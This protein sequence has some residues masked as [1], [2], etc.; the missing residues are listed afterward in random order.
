MNRPVWPGSLAIEPIARRHQR[1]SFDCGQARV[2]DWIRSKALQNHEKR[3]SATR[4]LADGI[5][6]A[7]YYTL[8]N[9]EIS[10][11]DLPPAMVKK[12]PQRHLPVAIIAWLGLDVRYQKQGLGE[13]LLGS[14]LCDVI[15]SGDFVPHVA[16]VIDSISPG[17]KSFFQRYQFEELP[18]QPHR[19]VVPWS[20]IVKMME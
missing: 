17:S 11:A 9:A 8:A 12:L 6:V 7:G 3:M 2:N 14:A 1:S 16:V 18:G 20:T 10:F 5:V 19:L 15:A 13:R 4:I